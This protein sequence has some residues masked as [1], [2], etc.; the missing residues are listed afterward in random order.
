MARV[1]GFRPHNLDLPKNTKQRNQGIFIATPASGNVRMEW[2][3]HRYG[4]IIPCNWGLK[5]TVAWVPA[6][7]PTGYLVADAQ[8][9]CVKTF[10][11]SDCDWFLFVE[12]DNLIPHDCFVRINDYMIKKTVPVVSG[13]YF[14]KSDPS[15]PILYRGRGNSYYADWRLG[16]KVWVDGVPTGLLLIHRSIL[17]VMWDTSSTY[18]AGD[19]RTRAVFRM[20]Q[21]V[22]LH[23]ERGWYNSTGT[24]DLEW[25]ARVMGE[26]VFAKAGWPKYQ[27]LRYPFLVDTKLFCGHID[28]SGRI[29]P[30]EAEKRKW[31]P[32]EKKRGPRKRARSA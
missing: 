24:S 27:K 31:L 19:V 9:I 16:D 13:L 32:K 22:Q 2:C 3:M 6:C 7:A 25:C 4:Q 10:L 20:P 18:L 5:Q 11:E 12:D 30:S 23:P 8:N 29:F 15:E 21:H 17:Q 1:T 14:T 28:P 26:K